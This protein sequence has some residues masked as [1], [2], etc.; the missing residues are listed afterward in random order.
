VP[1]SVA[2]TS[3]NASEIPTEKTMSNAAIF[4][5][6][7]KPRDFTDLVRKNSP[8]LRP[9][10]A[11]AY[12]SVSIRTLESWRAAGKGPAFKKN[13]N[14]TIRYHIDDLDAFL[15]LDDAVEGL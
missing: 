2:A 8:W 3:I 1:T 6:V 5:S 12:L 15:S 13:K 4:L 11:A 10:Q 7:L 9:A 14:G